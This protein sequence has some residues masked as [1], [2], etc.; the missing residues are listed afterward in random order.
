MAPPWHPMPP[1]DW[2]RY[3]LNQ[4]AVDVV[5]ADFAVAGG[6]D[7]AG[8]TRLLSNAD[9]SQRI[10]VETAYNGTSTWRFVPRAILVG[11]V[12]EGAWPRQVKVPHG[13]ETLTRDFWDMCKLDPRLR[14]IIDHDGPSVT[15]VNPNPIDPEEGRSAAHPVVVDDDEV[16]QS[17]D[18]PTTSGSPQPP[19]NRQSYGSTSSAPV[20][21][22]SE[23]EDNVPAPTVP[24][25]SPSFTP[26]TEPER[27]KLKRK[28]SAS[29]DGQRETKSRQ[30]RERSPS[31]IS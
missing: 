27:A 13:Y 18:S 7:P 31:I 19:R 5:F 23:G 3:L 29:P 21:T 11:V 15:H 24:Q 30:Y 1:W 10:I 8:V 25:P 28:A 17:E 9:I 12:D 26:P 20:D 6:D 4:S 16:A 14:C 2:P 22:E